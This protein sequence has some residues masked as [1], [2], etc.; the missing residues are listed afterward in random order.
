[1]G[2]VGLLGVFSRIASTCSLGPP[3]PFIAHFFVL[4]TQLNLVPCSGVALS[5]ETLDI[6]AGVMTKLSKDWQL[7]PLAASMVFGCGLAAFKCY[8]KVRGLGL[9][10]SRWSSDRAANHPTT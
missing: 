8:D 3:L 7:I 2:R 9:E 1:M 10:L 5:V 6:M 4:T